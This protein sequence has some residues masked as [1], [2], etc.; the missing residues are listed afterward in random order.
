VSGRSHL[1]IERLED[2]AM[3]SVVVPQVA[4]SVT[5]MSQNLSL[6]ADV[7]PVI[8][9]I[10]TGNQKTIA[11][12][13]TTAWK[14]IQASNFPVRAV[15]IASE[16]VSASPAIVG[17][18]EAALFHVAGA[19]PAVGGDYLQI[20]L[21]DINSQLSLKHASYTYKAVA[22]TNEADLTLS[23]YT[24]TG[25]P[26]TSI[27]LTDRDAILVRV[28]PVPS[29]VVS[30]VQ[31][32]QHFA[33][34]VVLPVGLTGKTVTIFR[35]WESVDVQ[36]GGQQFRVI[37]THLE[38]GDN[39]ISQAIQVTQALEL[40]KGPASTS[41][42]TILLG[43][44]NADADAG[45]LTYKLLVGAGFG[46]AWTKTHP[47]S[48]GYTWPL[49]P[50][51]GGNERIDLVL[52]RGGFSATSMSIVGTSPIPSTSLYPSDHAGVVATLALTASHATNSPLAAFY[53]LVDQEIGSLSGAFSAA[54]T[55]RQQPQGILDTI[56]QF[57][58]GIA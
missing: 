21:T 50:T 43:D 22:V 54:L 15:T 46:D 37:N 20:L 32:Q 39:L 1:S 11:S 52:F 18:Q 10:L 51:S 38:I 2:R 4:S 3:L 55:I 29:M 42:P 58:A 31:Q 23:G 12:A 40:L 47:N 45:A 27:E 41:R 48:R 17:L 35:G 49:P 34:D 36:Q 44:F 7:T 6:G 8:N 53:A 13:V 30:N 9:A 56:D 33:H 24:S 16:I 57:F 28:D 25:G 26:L 5:V 14:N 19:A